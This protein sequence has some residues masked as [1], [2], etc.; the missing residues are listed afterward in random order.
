M[1][2]MDDFP[3]YSSAVLM[4]PPGVGKHEYCIYL[5]NKWLDDGE[6][7]IFIT[8]ERSPEEINK[9]ISGGTKKKENLIFVDLFSRSIGNGLYGHQ[10]LLNIDD[11]ERSIERAVEK[12]G[13]PVRIIFDSLSMTLI[14]PNTSMLTGFFYSL[15]NKIKTKYGFI[16]YTL[17]EGVHDP[18]LT[19]L[20][21]SFV[22]GYLQMKFEDG[23]TVERK[24]RVHHFDGID[25]DSTW[26]LFKKE[27]GGVESSMPNKTKTEGKIN[28]QRTLD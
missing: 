2:I 24:F 11:I 23:E 16:L 17:Q 19:N 6:K 3:S 4:G 21:F 7:V 8:S 1:Q 14:G 18:Q 9:R 10:V 25:Y 15:T 5:L 28:A 20:I 12:F 26:A 27:G 22:N 13:P